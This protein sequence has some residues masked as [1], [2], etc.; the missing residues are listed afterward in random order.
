MVSCESFNYIPL[1][2]TEVEHLFY[3]YIPFHEVASKSFANFLLGCILLICTSFFICSGYDE[4]LVN[5]ELQMLQQIFSLF[6][7]C[8]TNTRSSMYIFS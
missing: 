7:W 3:L 6:L 2:S 1:I 5:H 4:S 8:L